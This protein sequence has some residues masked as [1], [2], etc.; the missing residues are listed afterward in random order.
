MHNGPY[1]CSGARDGH[2]YFFSKKEKNK[3]KRKSR[4]K[5]RKALVKGATDFETGEWK[6]GDYIK[7]L[8][9]IPKTGTDSVVSVGEDSMNSVSMIPRTMEIT[10][11][12]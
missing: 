6:F 8:K 10:E 4:F 11:K 12:T 1:I 7:F 3:Q 9:L 2:F 5:I